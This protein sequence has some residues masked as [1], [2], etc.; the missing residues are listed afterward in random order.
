MDRTEKALDSRF[1]II[2]M[3]PG[4]ARERMERRNLARRESRR[5]FR[6]VASTTR[7]PDTA[8]ADRE[9]RLS[10]PR[11][12]TATWFGD[13]APGWSALDRKRQGVTA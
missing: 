13:P 7:A 4:K 10:A 11:T 8:L 6:V 9:A 3:N 2:T 12:L 5:E 1:R